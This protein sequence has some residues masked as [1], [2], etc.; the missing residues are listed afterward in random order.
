MDELLQSEQM[1][2]KEGRPTYRSIPESVSRAWESRF[3]LHLNR[4]DTAFITGL[5]T[6]LEVHQLFS[7]NSSDLERVYEIVNE[8]TEG[9]PDTLKQRTQNAV[10]RLLKN[11]LLIRV[12]GGG[13][14]RQP[15]F[16]ISRL[17]KAIIGFMT[18]TEKLTR[19]NLTII[20][21]RIVSVLSEIRQ[22]LSG[23]VSEQYWEEDV[24]LPLKH[25]VSELLDAID[26]RQRGLDAEQDEVRNQ[27][28]RLLEKDWMDALESCES[29][30]E[31]T[32]ATLQELYKTV[33]SENASIKQGL[34]EIYEAA[35]DARHNEIIDLIDTI[36]LRLD[37]LEQWGKERVGSWS[38]YYRRVNDFLQSIVRFD[39]NR[40]LSEQLKTQILDYVKSPWRLSVI[41]P[42]FYRTLR[43]FSY[44]IPR[45]SITRQLS[46]ESVAAAEQEND[47]GRMVLDLIINDF[48]KELKAER[49]L[50][51]IS[52]IRPYLE[53]YPLDL[54]YPHIG[55][56]IDLMLKEGREQYPGSPQ[57]ERPMEEL[58]FELQNLIVH[59]GKG[60]E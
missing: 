29:L 58:R 13:I 22:S 9:N 25:V 54:I 49:S 43:E 27:I 28:S 41:D 60:K 21:S 40:E 6:F 39:P 35:D 17:G 12:D 36:Y 53:Q 59:S 23:G 45:R 20:T 18:N 42:P 44:P 50:D 4:E 33:L 31:T 10:E 8:V 37:Q 30:L 15:L 38:Q 46:D 24:F 52:I 16:D 3:Q 51:L 7:L 2:N 47:D 57:W 55:L 48:K 11:Q 1:E 14:A 34:N 5:Y 19:Q 26:K 32:S 56:L